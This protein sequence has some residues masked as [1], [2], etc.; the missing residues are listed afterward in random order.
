[1]M[2]LEDQIA[3]LAAR[4]DALHDLV[5]ATI[6]DIDDLQREVSQLQQ[7]QVAAQQRRGPGRPPKVR[8]TP[9]G[10]ESGDE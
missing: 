6:T 4:V 9:V 7:T 8:E 5:D 10:Q 1:M 3:L 2:T